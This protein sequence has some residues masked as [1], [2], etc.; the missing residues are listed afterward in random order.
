MGWD[1]HKG[2]HPGEGKSRTIMRDGSGNP[3]ISKLD[4]ETLKEIAK[5]GEGIFVRASDWNVRSITY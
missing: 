5:A 1:W 3:I 2:D 4:E